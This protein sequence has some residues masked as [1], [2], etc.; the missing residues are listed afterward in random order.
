M[1]QYDQALS[2]LVIEDSFNNMNFVNSFYP[3]FWGGWGGG[4]EVAY[5]L[6]IYYHIAF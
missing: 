3:I 2:L 5:T 6:K 1:N 4:E